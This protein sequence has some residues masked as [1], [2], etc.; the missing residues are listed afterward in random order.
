MLSAVKGKLLS[1]GEAREQL[2]IFLVALFCVIQ[3]IAVKNRQVLAP[4][5]LVDVRF[6]L[7]YDVLYF[8]A[9]KNLDNDIL[10]VDILL[11]GAEVGRPVT[12]ILRR[13]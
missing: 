12:F 8:G 5:V 3:T 11:C 13:N 4:V 2:M 1:V 9:G 7:L 6:A 10:H